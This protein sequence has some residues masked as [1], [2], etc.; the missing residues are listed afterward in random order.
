MGRFLGVDPGAARIG[1]ALSDEDARVALPCAT[2]KRAK[3]DVQAARQVREVL[4]TREDADGDG[5]V[6]ALEGVVVGL[7]LRLDGTEGEAVRRV[8]RFADALGD[9]LAVPVHF[10]DE[11]LSTVAVERTLRTL[12][13]PKAEQR[14]VVD[15]AAAAILLQAFLDARGQE[16]W[17]EADSEEVAAAD[18]QPSAEAAARGARARSKGARRARKQR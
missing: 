2:V 9:V 6:D 16:T 18:E 4:A 7:P 11:R 13:V 14:R 8:R 15:E 5:V 17:P 12:N 3:D 1:L 10:V